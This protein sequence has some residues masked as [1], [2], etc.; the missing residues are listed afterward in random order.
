MALFIPEPVFARKCR[1]NGDVT[2]ES[3]VENSEDSTADVDLETDVYRTL[4]AGFVNM[5]CD[6][7][8]IATDL[9]A[10]LK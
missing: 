6:A 1:I 10:T 8:D 9:N 3:A 7:V 2:A 5:P 4:L